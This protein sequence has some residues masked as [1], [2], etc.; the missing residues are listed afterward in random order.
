MAGALQEITLLNQFEVRGDPDNLWRVG[1]AV[2][3]K[4]T[5]VPRLSYTVLTPDKW[6]GDMF[7]CIDYLTESGLNPG[8]PSVWVQATTVPAIFASPDR[9]MLDAIDT[10]IEVKPHARRSNSSRR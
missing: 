2:K 4:G 9:W 1:F 3:P 8:L 10:L 7:K 6:G 5:V